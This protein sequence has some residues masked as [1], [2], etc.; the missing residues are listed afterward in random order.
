VADAGKTTYK[1]TEAETKAIQATLGKFLPK[2]AA[3]V[4]AAATDL[5]YKSLPLGVDTAYTLV[6]GADTPDTPNG[7]KGRM[8]L[9]EVFDVSE[10]IQG[11]I[12]KQAT[13]SEIEKAA[14]AEGMVN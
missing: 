2:T 9:Y 13:S 1:S 4:A 12:M 11:L 8:G 14:E 10:K 7:Y 3:E 6:K 5:G